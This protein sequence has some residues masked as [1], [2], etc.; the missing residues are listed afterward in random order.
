MIRPPDFMR[1]AASRIP[2]NTPLRL[3]AMWRSKSA[4]SDSAMLD[5]CMIPALFTSTSIATVRLLGKIE[6]LADRRRIADVG[7]DGARY[8]RRLR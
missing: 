8:D 4:S 7:L 1:R 2:L 5:S 6:H 3:M